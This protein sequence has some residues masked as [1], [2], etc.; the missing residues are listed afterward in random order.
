MTQPQHSLRAA[1][2]AALLVLATVG[3]A[4]LAVADHDE[5]DASSVFDGVVSV[6]EDDSADNSSMLDGVRR[7]ASRIA[8]AAS[9]TLARLTDRGTDQTASEAAD[10][11]QAEFNSHNA[12]IQSYINARA[13][14]STDA[15]VLELTFEIDDKTATRY[16][17]AD[18]NTSDGTYENAS[19]VSSTNREVD[20]SCSLEEQAADNAA[21]EIETFVEEFASEGEDMSASYQG[22]MASQYAGEVDCSFGVRG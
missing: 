17:V 2:L 6:E 14:A 16:V 3:A 15:N 11:A 13:S 5:S 8:G 19:M 12:T 21:T 22:R 10:S 1:A 18:V 4:P 7:A 9:G 20:E